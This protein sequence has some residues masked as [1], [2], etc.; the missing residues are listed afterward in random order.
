MWGMWETLELWTRNA[1][2]YCQQSTNGWCS[3]PLEGSPAAQCRGVKTGHEISQGCKDFIHNWARGQSHDMLT[4][5]LGISYPY[6]RTH[7]RLNSKQWTDFFGGEKVS[8]AQHWLQILIPSDSVFFLL[9]GK[10]HVGQEEMP[11]ASCF[12]CEPRKPNVSE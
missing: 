9:H 12:A 10:E 7:R 3:R 5:S 4:K 8:T 2:E 11:N 6:L 1:V